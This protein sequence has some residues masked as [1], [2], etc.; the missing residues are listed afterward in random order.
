MR[1]T[2]L[3]NPRV[4]YIVRLRDDSRLRRQE[5]LMLVE[6]WDEITLAQSAGHRPQTI[7]TA[8]SLVKRP[9]PGLAAETLELSAAVFEKLSYRQN[10]DGWMAVFHAPTH[11]LRSLRLSA[12][13]MLIVVE[14]VEKPGNL[15]AI[16]RTCDAAGVDAVIVCDP[17]ADLF[18]PNVVRASRGA[19]FS[20]PAIAAD[21]G[22]ARAFLDERGIRVAAATPSGQVAFTKAD[23]RGPL[24]IAV[25]TEDRGLS[26]AWLQRADVALKIPMRGHINSLNVSVAT[27][28]ILYEAIR[29]RAE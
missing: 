29:Q 3:Q 23:L 19:V 24:A 22:E 20:V 25:G 12:V 21:G 10:P 28:L 7:L 15:G 17:R 8:G 26:D 2:S 1:I 4:K 13:P 18:G 27:A 11:D 16:L 14:A 5:G 9:L 6:G